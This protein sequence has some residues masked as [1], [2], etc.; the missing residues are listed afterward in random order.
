MA[1]ADLPN[2][3]QLETVVAYGNVLTRLN[4]NND[5]ALKSLYVIDVNTN[6]LSGTSCVIEG[7]AQSASLKIGLASTPYTSLTVKN[8]TALTALDI[9]DNTQLIE[10]IA[11]G[12]PSVTSLN[13]ST[14]GSLTDL[15]V[16]ASGLTALD[17]SRNVEL[18]SLD[19]SSNA[20]SALNVDNNTALV[21]LDC[22]DN[23]LSTLRVSNN[24]LLDKLD[25][26][27][28]ALANI[29][30]RKNTVLKA[31]NVSGNADITALALGYNTILEDLNAA[32]TGLTDIDLSDNLVIKT[33][34]LSGCAGIHGINITAN[35]ALVDLNVSNMSITSLNVNGASLESLTIKGAMN[36]LLGQ[37]VVA[38]GIKGVIFYANDVVKILSIDEA[39]KKWGPDGGTDANSRTD[40]ATNTNILLS[41]GRSYDAAKWCRDKGKSWYLPAV[42]EAE[43]I[44]N[45]IE[46]RSILNDTLSSIGGTQLKF[47]DLYWTSTES[48]YLY[49]G[50]WQYHAYA[51][52]RRGSPRAF[53][54]TNDYHVRAIRAL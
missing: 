51:V 46:N 7:F 43:V 8:S 17:V 40:G 45:N 28:N 2:L 33:L 22:A 19:C 47:E 4:L 26:S 53:D 24:I 44:I 42:Y 16:N 12:N 18:V 27:D 39:S 49:S 54:R 9:T 6:A 41:T 15:D 11:S 50:E 5:I 23:G 35:T 25:C 1:I 48:V 32:D 38:S 21:N 34:N 13:I 29:N 14:L 30:V 37:Y 31:L 3:T 52:H 20:L 10:L 36:C